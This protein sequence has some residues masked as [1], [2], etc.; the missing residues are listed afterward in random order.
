LKTK[1]TQQKCILCKFYVNNTVQLCLLITWGK[2]HKIVIS[3]WMPPGAFIGYF[4]NLNLM[5]LHK[6]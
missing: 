1:Y 3:S 6:Y 5:S 2:F 4:L